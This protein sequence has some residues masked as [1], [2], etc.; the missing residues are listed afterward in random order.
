LVLQEKHATRIIH[1]VD[2]LHEKPGAARHCFALRYK[3]NAAPEK[4]RPHAD[5]AAAGLRVVLCWLHS[6]KKFSFLSWQYRTP[7][8]STD[9]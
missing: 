9:T 7:I 1:L 3:Y 2:N 4:R 5:I 6:K 8:L